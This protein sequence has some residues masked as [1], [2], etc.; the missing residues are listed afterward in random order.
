MTVR[1]FVDTNVLVYRHDT[2]SPV[3][4]SQADDWY[5]LLWRQRAGRLSYQVLQE[6]YSTLTRKLKPGL[7]AVKAQ[8]IVRI[9]AA[10]APM[11]VNCWLPERGLTF[12]SGASRKAAVARCAWHRFQSLSWPPEFRASRVSEFRCERR[13]YAMF[14]RPGEFEQCE[15][16]GLGNPKPSGLL[17]SIVKYYHGT[18]QFVMPALLSFVESDP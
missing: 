7:D 3:K 16:Q 10:W 4:R 6:L 15:T 9:L 1:V 11:P 12:A 8:Q 18:G 2:S 13:G 5:R 14:V 17:P